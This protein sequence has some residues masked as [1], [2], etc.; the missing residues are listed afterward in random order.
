MHAI[1]LFINVPKLYKRT[2]ADYQYWHMQL[3][4][5]PLVQYPIR[6]IL[7]YTT[8]TDYPQMLCSV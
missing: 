3:N 7:Q 6:A 2:Q 1:E 4:A 5:R 8:I